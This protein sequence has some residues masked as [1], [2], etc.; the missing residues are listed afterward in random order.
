MQ[1]RL[2]KII[3]TKNLR[4]ARTLL[5]GLKVKP[6]ALTSAELDAVSTYFDQRDC[7]RDFSQAVWGILAASD[8]T[9]YLHEK[10]AALIGTREGKNEL[11]VYS[12][13]L[14]ST[15]CPLLSHGYDRV[16]ANLLHLIE[17][18]G[19]KRLRMAVA[20]NLIDRDLVNEGLN[21]M[22]HILSTYG[23]DHAVT[24]GF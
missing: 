2:V 12:N 19:D 23:T 11:Y 5:Q 6:R 20:E 8:S 16:T 1:N 7:S 22:V 24:D 21:L 14:D 17:R 3:A 13:A 10:F 4:S 18:S 15:L 9:E